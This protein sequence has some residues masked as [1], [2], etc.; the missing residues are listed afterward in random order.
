[1]EIVEVWGGPQRREALAICPKS[2]AGLGQKLEPTLPDWQQRTWPARV[3]F[4]RAKVQFKYQ[5]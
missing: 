3:G 5:R 1:M 2:L 4:E